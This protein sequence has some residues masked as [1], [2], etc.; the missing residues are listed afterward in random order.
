MLKKVIMMM[1]NDNDD[2]DYCGLTLPQCYSEETVAIFL[3]A[4]P[5]QTVLTVVG[6]YSV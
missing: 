2:D 5:R 6:P 1:M 3:K 4:G